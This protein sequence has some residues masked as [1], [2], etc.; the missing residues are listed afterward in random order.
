MHASSITARLMFVALSGFDLFFTLTHLRSV[1]ASV[2]RA[3]GFF[4]GLASV[5]CQHLKKKW[6]WVRLGDSLQSWLV[7]SACF[8]VCLFSEQFCVSLLT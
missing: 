7:G 5:L 3:R 4:W 2:R 1:V 8:F 6:K